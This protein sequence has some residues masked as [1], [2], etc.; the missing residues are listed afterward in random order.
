MVLVV[1]PV[2]SK[3]YSIGERLDLA[4]CIFL[5]GK[6]SPVPDRLIE[7]PL[8]AYLVDDLLIKLLIATLCALA[9]N[10]CFEFGGITGRHA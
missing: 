3:C 2:P 4:V 9:A 1:R 10:A 7:M 6:D 8:C 5:I